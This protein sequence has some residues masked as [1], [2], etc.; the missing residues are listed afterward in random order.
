VTRSFTALGVDVA[1]AV[2]FV[3]GHFLAVLLSSAVWLALG[4]LFAA[5]APIPGGVGPEVLAT[6]VW[7]AIIVTGPAVVVARV[8]R[9][10]IRTRLTDRPSVVLVP[11]LLLLGVVLAV[12]VETAATPRQCWRSSWRR[13]SWSAVSSTSTHSTSASGR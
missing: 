3:V 6:V 9:A 10:P 8:L 2:V 4:A 1:D 11:P 5:V 7:L 13:S 12:V